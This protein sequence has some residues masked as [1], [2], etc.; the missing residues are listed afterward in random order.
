MCQ[1]PTS[2]RISTEP[3]PNFNSGRDIPQRRLEIDS[4]RAVVT[5]AAEAVRAAAEAHRVV[6]ERYRVGVIAQ[7]EVLDAEVALLQ[8]ELDRTRALAGVRLAQ[9]RLDRAVGR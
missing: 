1:S 9:A 5:A 4:G 3:P 8:A 7:A 6:T 2:R